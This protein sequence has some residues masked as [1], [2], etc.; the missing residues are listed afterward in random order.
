MEITDKLKTTVKVQ[1]PERIGYYLATLGNHLRL[2][3]YRPQN[4]NLLSFIEIPLMNLIGLI[5][6]FDAKK[7]IFLRNSQKIRRESRIRDSL[8]I[9]QN[10][11]SG[12]SKKSKVFEWI[13]FEPLDFGA[14]FHTDRVPF[15]QQIK[16]DQN[17]VEAVWDNYLLSQ[18]LYDSF[19]NEWDLMVLLDIEAKTSKHDYDDSE[20]FHMD[21]GH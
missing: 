5:F 16:V 11:S 19:H 4:L 17:E 3:D 12:P 6:S 8:K 9:N 15:W 10:H 21:L 20:D 13:E 14:S 7:L 1:Y 2:S 18:R